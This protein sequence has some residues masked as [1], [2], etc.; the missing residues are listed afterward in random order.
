VTY[1][2]LLDIAHGGSRE[3]AFRQLLGLFPPLTD[4]GFMAVARSG[5]AFVGASFYGILE[6][7][8]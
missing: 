5:A 2:A 4:I 6:R 7:V 1:P 8:R 3:F